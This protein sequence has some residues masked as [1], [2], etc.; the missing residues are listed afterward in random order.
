[1]IGAVTDDKHQGHTAD[2]AD[3]FAAAT[4]L[5]RQMVVLGCEVEFG[6]QDGIAHQDCQ[7]GD[8]ITQHDRANQYSGN[9]GD[10]LKVGVFHTGYIAILFHVGHRHANEGQGLHQDQ[11]PHTTANV[12]DVADPPEAAEAQ[13][14]NHGDEPIYAEAGHEIDPRVGVDI[15]DEA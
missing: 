3:G 5:V 9:M 11:H 13:R 4:G 2:H 12:A 14:Q 8:D 7:Q 10:I 1:M 6:A 15:E